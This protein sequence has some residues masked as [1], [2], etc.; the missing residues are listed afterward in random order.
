MIYFI[1]TKGLLNS[2]ILK[3][4]GFILVMPSLKQYQI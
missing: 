4:D 3:M 1:F 2:D